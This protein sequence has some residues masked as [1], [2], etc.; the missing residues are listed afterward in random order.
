MMEIFQDGVV[1]IKQG[2]IAQGK[3]ITKQKLI[4]SESD[5]G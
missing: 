1:E 5:G 4:Q 3:S 2:L